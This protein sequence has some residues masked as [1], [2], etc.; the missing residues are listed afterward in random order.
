MMAVETASE[1]LGTAAACDALG[2]ARAAVYRR[3]QPARPAG[4]AADAAAGARAR[5]A[6][7]ACSRRSTVRAFSIRRRRRSM[8][9]CSTRAPISARRARCTAC[10]TPPARSKS[11]AIRSG[12]P[13]TPRRNS[14]PRAEP[15]MEL[16]HHQTP[17]PGQVDLLLPVRHPRHLQS[18]R[19]RL[20][21]RAPRERRARRA[22]HRRDVREAGHSARATHA[23]CRPGRR[24]AQQTRRAAAG[25]SRGGQDAQPAVRVQRQ[26]V[27]R[28]PVQ[29]PEV[30][31]R[32]S[33]TASDRSKTGGRSARCSFPGTTTSTSTVASGSSRRPWSTS[34]RLARCARLAIGCSR[35]PMPR[36]RSAS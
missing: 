34:A 29:N 20:D 2:V 30:L 14:W 6:A 10:W 22:A 32:N 13:T 16:G 28:S 1:T 26:P 23:A 4:R 31:S 21:D 7:D 15:G 27:F 35:R 36:I 3:R 11:G 18:V 25:R 8:R 17:R 24:D 9:R 33:P 19:R 5:R 12:G